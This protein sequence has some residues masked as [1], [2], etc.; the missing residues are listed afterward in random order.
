[1]WDLT[2]FA[3]NVALQDESGSCISYGA[4]DLACKELYSHINRRCLVFLLCRNSIGSVIGYVSSLNN[5]VV[6]VL[7]NAD[8]DLDLLNN[9][10]NV[11]KPAFLWLPEEKAADFQNMNNVYSEWGYS[12]MKTSFDSVYP[13]FDELCL[14]LTTSGST[15]SPKFVRQSYK[16]VES[17]ALSI[18]QYLKLTSDERPIT[19][20]PMN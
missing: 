15:G 14:M 5:R 1:M 16:N 18:V 10:I 17:N 12:L 13:L 7:L 4:L 8:L 11:Y 3:S 9:L 6:P 19:T 2:K 20:L